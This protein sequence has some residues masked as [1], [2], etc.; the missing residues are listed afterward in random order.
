L[1]IE[2]LFFTFDVAFLDFLYFLFYEITSSMVP[3]LLK[4]VE[5]GEIM[6][7]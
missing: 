1:D 4:V 2:Y 3:D 5:R 6:Y 7:V